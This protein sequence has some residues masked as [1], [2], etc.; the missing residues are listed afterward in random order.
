MLIIRKNHECFIFQKL[1]TT[2]H[3]NLAKSP[4][5]P[6]Y[7]TSKKLIQNIMT[8]GTFP[9]KHSQHL[10]I[11]ARSIDDLTINTLHKFFE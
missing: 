2:F 10:I 11:T 1:L 3:R 6:K 4:L 5:G 8:Y 9:F 7:N